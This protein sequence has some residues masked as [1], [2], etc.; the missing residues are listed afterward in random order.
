MTGEIDSTRK[1]GQISKENESLN[2]MDEILIEKI[3]REGVCVNRKQQQK[4]T[5]PAKGE[6][7]ENDVHYLKS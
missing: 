3:Y 1:G 2:E 4:E 6:N 7:N 5:T